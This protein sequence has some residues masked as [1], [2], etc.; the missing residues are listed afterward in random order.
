MRK[1]SF[2]PARLVH[3][4]REGLVARAETVVIEAG[5]P[6]PETDG[7]LSAVVRQMYM[8]HNSSEDSLQTVS[9][10]CADYSMCVQHRFHIEQAFETRKL[11]GNFALPVPLI[12]GYPVCLADSARLLQH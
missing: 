7:I 12:L 11:D 10:Q 6:V 9:L 1:L 5:P 4:T 8:Q 2:L 3:S